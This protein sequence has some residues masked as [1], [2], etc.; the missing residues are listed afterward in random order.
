[1]K[2]RSTKELF[3]YWNVRRGVRA[4]PDRGDIEPGAI[5]HVLADTFILSYDQGGGHP[6]RIA[7]T[8]VCAVFGREVKNAA[9][10]DLWSPECRALVRDLLTFVANESIGV[11]AG[12]RGA[13]ADGIA[14]ELEVLLLPLSQR[15]RTDVRV[16]GALVPAGPGSWVGTSVLGLLTL[17]PLRYLGDGIGE[18]APQP[19]PTIPMGRIRHGFVVYDGGQ[20]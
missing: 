4:A 8:R 17:G 1:M 12:A 19:V 10:V 18:P 11:I 9:Y 5:R 13:G 14:R 3:E 15:G 7:G 6:F 2:H 16:L 20:A